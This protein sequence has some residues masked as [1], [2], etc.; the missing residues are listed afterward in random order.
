[1]KYPLLIIFLILT[2]CASII[3]QTTDYERL[4]GSSAPKQRI[5]TPEQVVLAEQQHKVSFVKDIKPILDSRCV[6]CHGCYDAP[7]Q[8]KLGSTDGLDRGATIL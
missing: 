4:Y 1:M 3:Y 8:L 7:C 2:S 6:S 5:L